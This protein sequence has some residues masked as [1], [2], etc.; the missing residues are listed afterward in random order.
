M[1]AVTENMRLCATCH[2]ARRGGGVGGSA[3][4]EAPTSAII[5]IRAGGSDSMRQPT[6]CGGGSETMLVNHSPPNPWHSSALMRTMPCAARC[7][8]SHLSYAHGND[9]TP[10]TLRMGRCLRP[11]NPTQ[12]LR[13]WPRPARR[14]EAGRDSLGPTGSARR[15]CGSSS[16]AS[17]ARRCGSRTANSCRETASSCPCRP[18]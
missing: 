16:C 7:A 15:A 17:N 6:T 11:Q 5:V 1:P 10:C 14:R 2:A 9:R 18:R 3:E 4:H 13:P 8:L 12:F